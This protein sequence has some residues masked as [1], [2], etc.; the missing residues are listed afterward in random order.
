MYSKIGSYK[1]IAIV[2]YDDSLAF[3]ASPE[4]RNAMMICVAAGGFMAN[5]VLPENIEAV[6]D[7]IE[8]AG[9]DDVERYDAIMFSLKSARK[10]VSEAEYRAILDHELGHIVLG[11]IHSDAGK[12]GKIIDNI[13]FEI[14]ADQFSV[15]QGNNPGALI[16]GLNK[17]IALSIV[18]ASD[19]HQF[20]PNGKF[21]RFMAWIAR[22][23][24]RSFRKRMKALKALEA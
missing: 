12:P 2:E 18:R 11:H 20:D 21:I 9:V 13:S 4:D 23:C 15:E 19:K 24:N 8:S 5:P 17:L 3:M 7:L 10:G 14:E 1:G 6:K 16:S 22:N